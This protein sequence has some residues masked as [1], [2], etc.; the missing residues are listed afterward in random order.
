M[1]L[2]DINITFMEPCIAEQGKI[3]L[4]AEMT[5]DITEVMPY[6]NTVISNAIFNRYAPL[7]SFTKDFR[8]I[9][10]YSN[11]MTMA[12][13]INQTDALQIISWLKDLI[14]ITWDKRDTIAPNFEKKQKPTVPQFYSWL[15]KTNCKKCGEVSCFAFATMILQGKQK[16]E[17]CEPLF[18]PDYKES[19]ETITEVLK[20]IL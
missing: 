20:A 2:K 6:L 16:I 1:L 8:L 17:N 4:K 3:R 15:P 7:I 19:R 11:N 18:T 5:N 9:V 12:K 10:L 14:N 13:A